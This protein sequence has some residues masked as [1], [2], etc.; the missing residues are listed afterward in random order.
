[1]AFARLTLTLLV[2]ERADVNR[3]LGD[4]IEQ[5]VDEVGCD[6]VCRR[7]CDGADGEHGFE[8]CCDSSC[9]GYLHFPDL[10]FQFAV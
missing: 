5:I 10:S 2:C 4:R 9:R 8:S 6:G 3:L 1:M 7:R